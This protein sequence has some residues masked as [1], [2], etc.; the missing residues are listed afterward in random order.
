MLPDFEPRLRAFAEIIVRVGLNLQPGQ[1][2]LITEP[3]ELQGVAR[4]AEIIV[5]AVKAAAVEAG[6]PHPAV[7]EVIW[8]DGARL[9]E[10]AVNKDWRG[11]VQLVDGNAR[12]MQANLQNQHAMLFLQG[13]QPGLLDGIAAAGVGELRRMA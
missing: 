4:S 9:R 3:Y 10:Y 12:R 6:C 13:S 11:F 7:I 2:L 8:G 1:R 5:E